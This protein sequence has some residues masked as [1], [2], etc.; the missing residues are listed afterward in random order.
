MRSVST[1]FLTCLLA[2]GG[3]GGSATAP[4]YTPGGGGNTP[5]TAVAT[6]IAIYTGNNQYGPKGMAL[7]DPLCT[8]V[9]DQNGHL[10]IGVTVTY[11]VATGGGQLQAPTSV[12]T[13]SNGIATSGSWT[14]GPTAGTQT[15]TASTAGVVATVTFTAT[16]Q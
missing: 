7:P 11:A 1:V 6:T 16:A 15:V 8:N 9:F 3:C 5:P 2:L 14:L 13:G 4:S 12:Q 10:M